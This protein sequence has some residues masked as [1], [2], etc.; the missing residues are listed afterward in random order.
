MF[1]Y[2]SNIF[3]RIILKVGGQLGEEIRSYFEWTWPDCP[4]KPH[5]L[6]KELWR[7]QVH[8]LKCKRHSDPKTMMQYALSL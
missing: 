3:H 4:R 5:G 8:T 1:S 2:F 7:L 6:L